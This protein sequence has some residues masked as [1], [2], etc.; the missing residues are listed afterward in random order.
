MLSE[1]ETLYLYRCTSQNDTT[2]DVKA[3]KCLKRL[4][5]CSS[6]ILECNYEQRSDG[7]TRILES[8]AFVA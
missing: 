1:S 6:V 3:V 8:V 4:I 2:L 5:D 7:F